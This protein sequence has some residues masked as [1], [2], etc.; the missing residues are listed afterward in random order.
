MSK[1]ELKPCPFCGS[2]NVVK[3]YVVECLDCRA[4]AQDEKL[5]NMRIKAQQENK[6]C[7]WC[8]SCPECGCFNG[9]MEQFLEKVTR[10]HGNNHHASA[11]KAVAQVAKMQIKTNGFD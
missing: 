11:Y 1:M 6:K 7:D 8:T 2:N 10:T 3:R 9:N 5:W 4:T